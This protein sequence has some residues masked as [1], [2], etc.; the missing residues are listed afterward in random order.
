[1]AA[2]PCM[3]F[4]RERLPSSSRGSMVVVLFGLSCHTRAVQVVRDAQVEPGPEKVLGQY[5]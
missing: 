1:M 3:A 5:R 4:R 2:T